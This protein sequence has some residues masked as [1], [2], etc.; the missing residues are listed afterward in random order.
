MG[1]QLKKQSEEF[2]ELKQ[3]NEL[4]RN[5]AFIKTYASIIQK[6]LLTEVPGINKTR[7]TIF[8]MARI[9][10]EAEKKEDIEKKFGPIISMAFDDIL[11][12]WMGI[13][14]AL[15]RIAEISIERHN[16]MVLYINALLGIQF[17]SELKQIIDSFPELKDIEIL[18]DEISIITE[19]KPP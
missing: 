12:S 4:N 13:R 18:K 15:S 17:L 16:M 14:L 8:S 6:E 2:R 11:S 9:L 5:E 19:E 1:M 3:N 10:I 7:G